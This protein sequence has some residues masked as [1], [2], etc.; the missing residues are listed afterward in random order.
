MR[1]GRRAGTLAP[2]PPHVLERLPMLTIA[3]VA[4]AAT[5]IVSITNPVMP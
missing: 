2:L 3:L 1:E 4:A 5:V